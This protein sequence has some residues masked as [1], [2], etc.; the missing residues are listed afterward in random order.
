MKKFYSNEPVPLYF[1]IFTCRLLLWL[2]RLALELIV[3]IECGEF[4]RGRR[5]RVDTTT[6][7]AVV[8]QGSCALGRRRSG[9]QRRSQSWRRRRRRQIGRILLF[10]LTE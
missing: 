1:D 2:D 6:A 9:G 8:A 10:A 4:G 5:C 7:I 3:N